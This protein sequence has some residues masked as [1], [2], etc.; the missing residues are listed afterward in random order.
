MRAFDVRS[1][2]NNFYRDILNDEKRSDWEAYALVVIPA[3]LAQVAVVRHVDRAFVSTM[4]T[5]LAILFGFTFSSLLTTARYSPKNDRVEEL[6][7]KQTRLGTAYALLVNLLTLF[8]VVAIS[9]G[10]TE[11]N[12]LGYT[13]ATM[14][15]A[16][17]YF[18]LFHYLIVMLYLMRYLYLLTVGG[19]FEE[20]SA[21]S[22]SDTE[23]AD[24]EQ[25][26]VDR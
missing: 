2:V 24:S 16:L 23:T 26:R 6:V 14:L 7:V 11:Y 21:A 1:I 19:A 9:I 12:S 20:P 22:A 3:I 10:V 4:S 17:T 5:T 13:A 18:A 15:S 8:T 25:I